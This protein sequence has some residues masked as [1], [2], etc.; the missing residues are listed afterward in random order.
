MT[1]PDDHVIYEV[2]IR[3]ALPIKIIA[4]MIIGLGIFGGLI[5]NPHCPDDRVI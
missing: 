1:Q 2:A 4:Q 3:Y 5:L